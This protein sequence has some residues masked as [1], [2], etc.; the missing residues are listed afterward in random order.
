DISDAAVSQLLR[1]DPQEWTEAVQGQETFFD[2]FGPRLPRAIR[3]EHDRLANRI[4]E[5]VTPADL[6]GRDSGT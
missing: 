2:S 6:R 4:G 3:E 5:A 1:V